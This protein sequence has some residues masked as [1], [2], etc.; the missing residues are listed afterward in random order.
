MT[1]VQDIPYGIIRHGIMF[2]V[3][4]AC[5][6]AEEL[7]KHVDFAS[8]GTNDLTQYLFAVDRDNDKVSYDYNPDRPVFWILL[9]NMAEAARAAGKSLSVCGEIA[10][11]PEYLPQLIKAGI[12]SVSVSPRRISDVRKSAADIMKSDK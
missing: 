4:A 11:F 5:L 3:P 12:D 8:I 10:G 7:F 6:Q 1:A 9:K 2:E